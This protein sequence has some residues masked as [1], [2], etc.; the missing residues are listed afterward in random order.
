[1]EIT[2]SINLNGKKKYLKIYFPLALRHYCIIIVN[3]YKSGEWKR[4]IN[5]VKHFKFYSSF[6]TKCT[7][8]EWMHLNYSVRTTTIKTNRFKFKNKIYNNIFF[9][10]CRKYFRLGIVSLPQHFD[11]NDVIFIKFTEAPVF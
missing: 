5:A 4:A 2:V 1:M 9:S 7:R 10:E 6:Q 11:R 3:L 8:N